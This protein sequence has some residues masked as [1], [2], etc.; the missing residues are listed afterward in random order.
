MMTNTMDLPQLFKTVIGFTNV[1]VKG[2]D[3]TKL[4]R[5]FT[6]C[7]NLNK[8]LHIVSRT[9]TKTTHTKHTIS[10]SSGNYITWELADN[11]KTLNAALHQIEYFMFNDVKLTVE[12]FINASVQQ[13]DVAIKVDVTITDHH[14]EQTGEWI[15]H[16]GKSVAIS[17]LNTVYQSFL[18]LVPVN[19]CL[20]PD[21][22]KHTECV[23]AVI[24]LALKSQY[25]SP[26]VEGS[27]QM[28]AH[29]TSA[30]LEQAIWIGMSLSILGDGV[31]FTLPTFLI[32][33]DA[34]CGMTVIPLVLNDGR[35]CNISQFTSA[36]L[37]I[38]M[39]MFIRSCQ[40]RLRRGGAIEKGE[41]SKHEKIDQEKL[42]QILRLVSVFSIGTNFDN[43][44]NDMYNV[45]VDVELI[46]ST[47]PEKKLAETLK[48][49]IKHMGG[50][51][52]SG[53][54]FFEILKDDFGNLVACMHSGSRGLGSKVYDAMKKKLPMLEGDRCIAVNDV[55]VARVS[56]IYD[57]LNKFALFN[58]AF[59]YYILVDSMSKY[60][61]TTDIAKILNAY[62]DLPYIKTMECG[63]EDE[64]VR[65]LA[66]GIIHNGFVGF[67]CIVD[68]G[69]VKYAIV[70]MKGA[71]TLSQ[72]SIA[73][74]ANDCC[75][76]TPGCTI[77]TNSYQ[78]NVCEVDL[79]Q[80]FDDVKAGLA[81]LVPVH[82]P[83]FRGVVTLPH[84]SG[85]VVSAAQTMKKTS[86]GDFCEII[87]KLKGW[88]ISPDSAGDCP[89]KAYKTQ[90]LKAYESSTIKMHVLT[91]LLNFK[92]GI[93]HR[94][95]DKFIQFLHEFYDIYHDEIVA[96]I[97]KI[98]NL[99]VLSDQEQE[100]MKFTLAWDLIL[101]Y[102]DGKKNRTES[103]P[104]F[105]FL[106]D[107]QTSIYQIL[108]Q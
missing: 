5:L 80:I 53:N 11:I 16:T 25:L 15:R 93:N 51:G 88:S 67:K 3:T 8:T 39:I 18:Y 99:E 50:F 41:F 65:R 20:S 101:V 27:L 87:K 60:N 37:D 33:G 9:Q 48:F 84:G 4:M 26:R 21:P 7:Y 32:G 1:D 107:A 85:R 17:G 104:K 55:D 91:T 44:L 63:N 46:K 34:G 103:D 10:H 2:T 24:K 81:T 74:V 94:G 42:M 82:D 64:A 69:E 75:S 83:I 105:K 78:G 70:L 35:L 73:I 6:D 31:A 90:D 45:L 96:L 12:Q 54:H 98:I 95:N 59:C 61:L 49:I 77:V 58:R 97:P 40:T 86:F 30:D 13:N 52:S 14:S 56:A 28:D 43:F 108:E 102:S 89:G 76:S 23:M 100:L 29:P 22:E 66:Q 19:L 71:V 36:Q 72:N 38:F 68:G 47:T 92:E 57:S 79:V 106:V 62:K